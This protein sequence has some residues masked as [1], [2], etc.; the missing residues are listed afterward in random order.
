MQNNVLTHFI[1]TKFEVVLSLIKL[2]D[3]RFSSWIIV[4]IKSNFG[5]VSHSH[6]TFLTSELYPLKVQLF[7]HK[8]KLKSSNSLCLSFNIISVPL[9]VVYEKH[10]SV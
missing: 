10:S 1:V 6:F 2:L 9:S 4:E 7:S 3:K 5:F 8:D